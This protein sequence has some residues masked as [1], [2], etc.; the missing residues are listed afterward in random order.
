MTITVKSNIYVK[1]LTESIL[2]NI[3]ND[4]RNHTSVLS[5]FIFSCT[6]KIEYT[7]PI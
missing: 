5:F 4:C 3:Q 7:L 1:I 2:L 6:V